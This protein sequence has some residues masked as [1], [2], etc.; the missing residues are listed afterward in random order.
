MASL[1]QMWLSLTLIAILTNRHRMCGA[2]TSLSQQLSTEEGTTTDPWE[3]SLIP[4]SI[5]P[6]TSS[7]A[8]TQEHTTD[9][10]STVASTRDKT[11]ERTSAAPA[12]WQKTTEITITVAS[13]RDKTAESTD[14]VAASIKPSS[15]L[16]NSLSTSHPNVV[17][18]SP[19]MSSTCPIPNISGGTAMA[20]AGGTSV[21]ISCFSGYNIQ[22]ASVL[23][24]V[25]GSWNF[26]VPTCFRESHNDIHTYVHNKLDVND[27][28]LPTWLLYTL[29]AVIGLLGFLLLCC[30][31]YVCL[32]MCGCT[33]EPVFGF[34]QVHPY[35][36]RRSCF[37]CCRESVSYDEMDYVRRQRGRTLRKDTELTFSLPNETLGRNGPSRRHRSISDSGLSSQPPESPETSRKLQVKVRRTRA[38]SIPTWLPHSHPKRNNNTSTN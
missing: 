33:T 11:T 7:A 32:K 15:I 34:S 16:L 25:N 22:G 20:S 8:T 17:P 18:A 12:T 31:L 37:T 26:P 3:S 36:P 2:S 30:V 6:S 4:T 9:I 1:K 14:T 28:G 13:T 21:I 24:C 38:K 23:Q 27:I 29:C 10:P 19:N 5:T 35:A